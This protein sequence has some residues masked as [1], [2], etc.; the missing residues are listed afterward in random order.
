[1]SRQ[2]QTGTKPTSTK[3]KK[4]T[5]SPAQDKPKSGKKTPPNKKVEKAAPST[6]GRQPTGSGSHKT[7]SAPY[8]RNQREV[9][10]ADLRL[11]RRPV[12]P[13]DQDRPHII[14]ILSAD[15]LLQSGDYNRALEKFNE[16]LGRFRQSPRATFGKALALEHIAVKKKSN[17]LMDTAIDFYYDVAFESVLANDDLKLNALIRLAS[18]AQNRGKINLSIRA[19]QKASEMEPT[20]SDYAV[21]V[22]VA[23]MNDKQT[24]KAVEQ[25]ETVLKSWPN[26]SL[27][28][29]NL[30]YLLYR[31]KRYEEAVT[32]LLA[33]ARGKGEGVRS[34]PKYYLYA[35]DALVRLNR[36]DEVRGV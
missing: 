29:A 18:H 4:P 28:H 30:G 31:E 15:D 21:R 36:S 5:K 14:E 19:L 25:F 34:D 6:A 23:L 11:L 16:I 9:K 33:G 3:R 12:P 2:E 35:G 7:S 17:K 8:N 20:N 24:D 26:D 32:H 27:A 13:A 22:G 1:M 10:I